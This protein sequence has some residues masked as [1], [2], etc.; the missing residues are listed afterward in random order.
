MQ[1]RTRL[2]MYEE[3]AAITAREIERLRHKNAIRRSGARQPSEK[4]RE[5]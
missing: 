4:D 5:L 2:T 1:Q 3:C